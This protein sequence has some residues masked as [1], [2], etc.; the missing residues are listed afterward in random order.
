MS[1][2]LR[3]GFASFQKAKIASDALKHILRIEVKHDPGVLLAR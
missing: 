3:D 2:L 1:A